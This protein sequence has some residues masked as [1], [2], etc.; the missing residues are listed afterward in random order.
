M[1]E[2]STGHTDCIAL[3]TLPTG[4]SCATS[5]GT[6]SEIRKYLSGWFSGM[7][8]MTNRMFTLST[9]L[10]TSSVSQV[11]FNYPPHNGLNVCSNYLSCEIPPM[12]LS[13]KC[14]QLCCLVQTIV[15][16]IQQFER[17]PGRSNQ[18]T[19]DRSST[20]RSPPNSSSH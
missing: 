3:L 14:G 18:I 6:I 2:I 16:I 20:I 8:R 19:R 12:L 15:D 5:S 9:L 1:T 4:V 11:P 13:L 7:N 17:H 10:S